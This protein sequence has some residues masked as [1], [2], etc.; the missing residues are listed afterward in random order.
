MKDVYWSMTY[1]RALF[2]ERN[3]LHDEPVSL[4]KELRQQ[5]QG[6]DQSIPGYLKCPSFLGACNNVFVVRNAVH[7]NARVAGLRQFTA[8]DQES[9]DSVTLVRE[10]PPTRLGY[11]IIGYWLHPLFF[12]TEPLMMAVMPAFMHHSEAQTKM[13][14]IPGAFDIGKWYRPVDSAFELHPGVNQFCFKAGDPMFYVK[15]FT[16][17]RVRLIRYNVTEELEAISHGCTRF[18][19]YV[20]NQPLEKLYGMFEQA[21]I[22]S[23]TLQL[24]NENL[25]N[26]E[27]NESERSDQ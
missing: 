4:L 25:A 23:R 18:S 16:E 12:S 17:E 14:Y 3:I 8:V 22:R 27:N 15:F 13:G 11:R 20:P 19:S 26:P 10:R 9:V 2:S 24:I 7:V 6:V 21:D 5:Q 1:P